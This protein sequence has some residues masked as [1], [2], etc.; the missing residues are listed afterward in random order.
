MSRHDPADLRTQ[1]PPPNAQG[2]ADADPRGIEQA[3]NL[4]YPSSRRSHDSDWSGPDNVCEAVA[5]PIHDRSPTIGTEK[6]QLMVDRILLQRG[7]VL[8][9]H[10]VRKAEDVQT[11]CKCL[12]DLVCGEPS[13]N[14]HEG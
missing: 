7:L 9:R 5:D 4:L 2:V 8:E 12:A 3:H 14:R 10:A 13:R 1:V 11:R 6:Q